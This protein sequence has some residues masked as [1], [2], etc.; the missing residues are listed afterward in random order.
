MKIIDILK[1]ACV[2][3]GM[4]DEC[5]ILNTATEETETEVLQSNDKINKL[6]H[7]MQYSIRELCTNYVPIV[8]TTTIFTDNY[9]FPTSHLENYI[10]INKITRHNEAVKYKMLN[11]VLTFEEDGE[12]SVEYASYPTLH[13]IFEE[14]DFLSEFSP[15]VIVMGLCA[16]Y[17]LSVGMFTEAEEY[18]DKYISKAESLKVLK[19]FDMPQRR[20]EW[21]RKK[22]LK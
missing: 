4:A 18:H 16:Y 22:L 21:E 7:L 15:D 17:C 11:R 12:Y 5:Q 8:V 13:S 9:C 14:I 1:D 6:F 20:W 2:L 10:R 19:N 3:I